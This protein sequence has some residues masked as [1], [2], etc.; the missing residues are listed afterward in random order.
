MRVLK[1]GRSALSAPALLLAL[2]LTLAACGDDAGDTDD[3]TNPGGGASAGAGAGDA[4]L[5]EENKATGEP[6]KIGFAYEGTSAAIDTAKQGDAAEA[7]VKYA[8]EY[9]GG[10][11]G[12]PIELFKCETKGNPATA[13]DCGNQFVSEK[14]LA[15]AGGSIGQTEPIIKAINAEGIPLVDILNQSPGTLAPGSINF[16]ISNPLNAFGGAAIYAKEQGIKQVALVVIDVPAAIEPAK[17]LGPLLFGN[18]GAKVDVIGIAPGVADASSQIQAAESK[19]PGLYHIIGNPPF[20]ASVVKA[21]KGLGLKAQYTGIDRCLDKVSA[22]S[23]PGGYEGFKVFTPANLDPSQ[24]ETELYNAVREKYSPDVESDADYST[25]YQGVLGLIRALNAGGITDFT[26]AGAV[27]AIKSMPET[28][29][30][31][32]GGATFQCNGTQIQISASICSTGGITA[33][34]TEDGGVE[35]FQNLEDASIYKLPGK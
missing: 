31:L 28:P 8:N 2:S 34:A 32:A 27:K 10:I 20:C 6:V 1:P 12:R 21:I 3:V 18:A 9:L 25:G 14:I 23:I 4:A 16:T 17:Q 5:G 22:A 35:N 13:G 29:I 15:L 7:V 33:D 26:P 11:G 19:K 24:E 30:P